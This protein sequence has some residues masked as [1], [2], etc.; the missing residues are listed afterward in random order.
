MY[1]CFKA[2]VSVLFIAVTVFAQSIPDDMVRIP[3]GSFIMKKDNV[4]ATVGI[5]TFYMSKTEITQAQYQ[6]AMGNNPSYFRGDNLPV[7]T[8]TW[9][10][11][12]NYCNARSLK[13]GREQVYNSEGVADFSKNGYRLP[14]TA[15]WEYAARAGNRDGYPPL[16]QGEKWDDYGWFESNS[17]LKTQPVGRKKANGFGLYDMFGNVSE[18]TNDF[19]EKFTSTPKQDPRG[20]V[21]G[22]YFGGSATPYYRDKEKEGSNWAGAW[23]EDKS[24]REICVYKMYALGFR[25]VLPQQ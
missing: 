18:W 22:K 23:T 19:P 2:F 5:T 25:V 15:E 4:T 10:D 16:P 6:A 21:T 17:D 7:E 11:A 3:G 8:V 1:S 9:C 12:I 24:Y 13:E 20:A 14:T